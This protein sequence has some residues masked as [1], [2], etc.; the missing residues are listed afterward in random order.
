[1]DQP[2]IDNRT[3]EERRQWEAEYEQKSAPVV[4]N[5]CLWWNDIGETKIRLE[6]FPKYLTMERYKH[7][8]L[9]EHWFKLIETRSDGVC[10]YEE[11]G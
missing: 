9:V 11:I 1:M 4:P 5:A 7:G 8:V 6:R 2:K 10:M 3:E